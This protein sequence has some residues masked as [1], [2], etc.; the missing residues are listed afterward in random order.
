MLSKQI[1][2]LGIIL[3]LIPFVIGQTTNVNCEYSGGS[4]VCSDSGVDTASCTAQES[5]DCAVEGDVNCYGDVTCPDPGD[6]V[7]SGP[8]F[9]DGGGSTSG[10]KR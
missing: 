8:D 5:S 7:D 3:V 1:W 4:S 2:T 9:C 6:G 10:A